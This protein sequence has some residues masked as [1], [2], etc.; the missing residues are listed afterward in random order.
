MNERNRRL[1]SAAKAAVPFSAVLVVV[2]TLAA[3]ELFGRRD[4]KIVF[5]HAMGFHVKEIIEDMA[6]EYSRE[7]PGVVIDPVF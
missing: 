2:F 7:R 4:T 5:W 3:G 1:R 6:A